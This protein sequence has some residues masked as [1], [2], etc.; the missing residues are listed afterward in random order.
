MLAANASIDQL[1]CYLVQIHLQNEN[2]LPDF[3]F[4]PDLLL[5]PPAIAAARSIA[6]GLSP[7]QCSYNVDFSGPI[8]SN[9]VHPTNHAQVFG[10]VTSFAGGG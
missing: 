10:V 8:I 1:S 3:F 2:F 7:L 4:I 9:N 5:R 6:I